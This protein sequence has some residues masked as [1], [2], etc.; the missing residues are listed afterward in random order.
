MRFMIIIMLSDFYAGS[1]SQKEPLK[2]IF[3]KKE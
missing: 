1:E 3:S 2:N